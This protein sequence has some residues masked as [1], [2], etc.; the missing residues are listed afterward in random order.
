MGFKNQFN[1]FFCMIIS[2]TCD[3][4]LE[5]NFLN[6]M[7]IKNCLNDLIKESF[8]LQSFVSKFQD[9]EI[10]IQF[11]FSSNWPYEYLVL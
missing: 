10:F 8:P 3:L 5:L 2:C 7:N 9:F 6:L 11:I 4:H 1:M